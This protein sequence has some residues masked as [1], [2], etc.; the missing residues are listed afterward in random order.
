MGNAT[1][2]SI[3]CLLPIG[4]RCPQQVDDRCQQARRESTGGSEAKDGGRALEESEPGES[5]ERTEH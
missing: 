2:E 1:F 3:G 4:P 5:Q